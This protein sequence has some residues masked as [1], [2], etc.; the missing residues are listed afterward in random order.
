[1]LKI[2]AIV[3]NRCLNTFG[4]LL[5]IN[6]GISSLIK[7]NFLRALGTHC[8][9]KQLKLRQSCSKVFS[10][11][12][13]T[14][15]VKPVLSTYSKIEK[16]EALNDNLEHSAILLTIGLKSNFWFSF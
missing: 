7:V 5:P 3:K 13:Y 15:K 8:I 9:G 16:N 2:C 10:L 12:E 11:L 4:E 14:N 1:M 6:F